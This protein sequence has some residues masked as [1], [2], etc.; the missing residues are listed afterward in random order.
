MGDFF[1]WGL[2]LLSWLNGSDTAVLFIDTV[3]N[4]TFDMSVFPLLLFL[5]IGLVFRLLYFSILILDITL[6]WV[7][8]S[9]RIHLLLA[10]QHLS[11]SLGTVFLL[12]RLILLLRLI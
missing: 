6:G 1:F 12:F 8:L 10:I 4:M 9:A 2:R 3:L 7:L 11:L 5:D